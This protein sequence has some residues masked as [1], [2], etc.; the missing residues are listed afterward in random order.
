MGRFAC[1]VPPCPDNSVRRTQHLQHPRRSRHLHR[2]HRQEDQGIACDMELSV[3]RAW[4]TL[5]ECVNALSAKLNGCHLIVTWL[6]ARRGGSVLRWHWAFPLCTCPPRPVVSWRQA[7]RSRPAAAVQQ[8]LPRPGRT[9]RQS[10][11]CRGGPPLLGDT[12]PCKRILT[13]STYSNRLIRPWPG[14]RRLGPCADNPVGATSHDSPCTAPAGSSRPTGPSF[15]GDA[16]RVCAFPVGAFFHT[17]PQ[18]AQA[19]PARCADRAWDR[20]PLSCMNAHLGDDFARSL[21]SGAI[22]HDVL[23]ERKA[24]EWGRRR[25]ARDEKGRRRRRGGR[26]HGCVL[27]FHVRSAETLRSR[28][29]GGKGG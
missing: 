9:C 4:N 22:R 8:A 10:P 5:H 11:I 20:S 23:L 24:D 17:S 12:A 2:R 14:F 27:A 3:N 15:A 7:A 16:V 26:G 21:P 28:T 19:S 18:P 6:P 13:L 25:D 29:D 1:R